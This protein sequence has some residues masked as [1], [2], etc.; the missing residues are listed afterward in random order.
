MEG[1][2]HEAEP[3]GVVQRGL[4]QNR[5]RLAAT[6]LPGLAGGPLQRRDVFWGGRSHPADVPC[7]AAQDSPQF[8]FANRRAFGR[9]HTHLGGQG[10]AEARPTG[11]A[12][13]GADEADSPDVMVSEAPS[14]GDVGEE[15]PVR[16]ADLPRPEAAGDLPELR[17]VH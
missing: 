10:L 17:S 9:L 4:D 2:A 3:A 12:G 1:S 15:R 11:G 7:H 8:S 5:D 16:L 6:R 14:D 13:G